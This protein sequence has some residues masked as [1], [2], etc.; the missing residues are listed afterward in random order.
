MSAKMNGLDVSHW[1][2][3]GICKAI[4]YDFCIVKATDGTGGVDPNFKANA[5]DVLARGKKLGLYHFAEGKDAAAEADHF[6]ETVKPY[7][8]KAIL[9][10]DW[11]A[12]ALKQGRGWVQKFVTELRAK[13]KVRPVIYASASPIKVYKLEDLA[14]EQNCG[15]WCANYPLKG[16]M[17]YRQDLTP[18]VPCLIHQYTS[19]GQ[20]HGHSGSLDLDLFFG[21]AAL[22]DAWAK[23]T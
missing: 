12:G 15:I 17:G 22:W 10:L 19:S 9:V 4:E 18:E 16:N 7:V 13:A 20:L 5:Q 14:K 8:G 23:Q 21:D 1:Q 2:G 6:Y 3:P 11:E